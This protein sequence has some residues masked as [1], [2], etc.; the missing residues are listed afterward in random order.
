ML[1]AVLSTR[2][3]LRSRQGCS[4]HSAWTLHTESRIC[5]SA[6]EST[7]RATNRGRATSRRQA[8]EPVVQNA[9]GMSHPGVRLSPMILEIV[10]WLALRALI[11]E[12]QVLTAILAACFGYEVFSRGPSGERVLL[13][14]ATWRALRSA[15]VAGALV[16]VASRV[17]VGSASSFVAGQLGDLLL[18]VL[19]SVTVGAVWRLSRTKAPTMQHRDRQRAGSL[20]G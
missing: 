6:R 4:S 3:S 14:M 18:L 5:G 19:V 10:L 13:R 11:H 20:D 16:A 17:I 2:R 15:S 1:R 12:F 7:I 9:P 8:T